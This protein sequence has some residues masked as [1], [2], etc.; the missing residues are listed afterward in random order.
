MAPIAGSLKSNTDHGIRFVSLSKHRS[1]L[2]P[3]E[4]VFGVIY[5]KVICRGHFTSVIDLEKNRSRFIDDDSQTM[6]HPFDWTGT[7]KPLSPRQRTEFCPP[8]RRHQLSK[9]QQAKLAL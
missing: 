9:V 2:N 1:R 4:T 6:A 8:H 3:I 7:G 5:R